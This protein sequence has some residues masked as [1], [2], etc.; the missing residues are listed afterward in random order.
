MCYGFSRKV[1]Q[2]KTIRLIV[3]HVPEKVQNFVVIFGELYV[4][5]KI[6]RT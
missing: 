5:G 4:L 2:K 1:Q 6:T 3:N